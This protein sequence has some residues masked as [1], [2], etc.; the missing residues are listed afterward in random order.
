M[1]HKAKCTIVA[2]HYVR[3]MHQT[4]YPDIK[5]LLIKKFR[6]QLNYIMR[7]YVVIP[8]EDYVEFLQGNKG[9]PENSCILTFDDGFKDHYVNVFPILK[10]RKLPASFFP[11]TQPL[12]GFVVPAV[13][14]TH[15]L[16]AKIGS[17][18]FAGQFNQI[19]KEQ[20]PKLAKKFLVDDKAKKERGYRWDD[21]LTVNLKRA[22][23]KMPSGPRAKILNQIF[24]K[25]FKN[26]KQFCKQLYMNQHE[27]R[28]MISGGMSFGG[29]THTHPMLSRLTRKEQ[30]NELK[31]SKLILE[32]GLKTKIKLFAYPY[33]DFNKATID[34]LK[35]QKY[36]CGLTTDNGINKENNTRP[37]TLKRLDTND[38]PFK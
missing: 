37:F 27:M 30:I 5:G 25:Y 14:K 20:F 23:A 35:K 31:T 33:G 38:L 32:K 3:N 4:A 19:L 21:A 28:E 24:A 10:R 13:H 18:V 16:L 29:H 6:G 34:I 15:F 36:T 2:Y 7:N 22:V 9:I 11:I 1:K 12:T 8:L 26:E 17:K